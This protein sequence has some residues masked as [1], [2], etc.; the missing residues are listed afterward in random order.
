VVVPRCEVNA[1]NVAPHV[2]LQN[3]PGI[4]L[5]IF[6]YFAHGICLPPAFH[7]LLISIPLSTHFRYLSWWFNVPPHLLIRYQQ[8]A[9]MPFLGSPRTCS[10]QRACES[11][12]ERHCS[13]LRSGSSASTRVLCALCFHNSLLDSATPALKPLLSPSSGLTFQGQTLIQSQTDPH[14]LRTS[15]RSTVAAEVTAEADIE[16]AARVQ[17]TEMKRHFMWQWGLSCAT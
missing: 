8:Q 4:H 11:E 2:C 14:T 3:Y 6:C 15:Q 16:A 17:S 7:S 10:P 12:S 13:L 9:A 1:S 5:W